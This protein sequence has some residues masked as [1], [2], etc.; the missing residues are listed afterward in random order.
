M[1]LNR[2]MSDTRGQPRTVRQLLE[3]RE[4]SRRITHELHLRF[5]LPL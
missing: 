2:M 4:L 1:I 5:E 3:V